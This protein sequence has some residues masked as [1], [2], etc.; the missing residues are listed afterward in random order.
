MLQSL[1]IA[2]DRAAADLIAGV[3]RQSG[4]IS[5]EHI[6]CPAPTHYQLSRALSTLALDAVFVDTSDGGQ[7][8][9]LC[10][11]IARKTSRTAIVGFNV[12]RTA[13]HESVT[14]HMLAWPLSSTGVRETVRRAVRETCG[15]A[16][17]NLFCVVPAKGGSGATTVTVNVACHLAASF[18]KSVLVAEADLR[19]GTIADRLSTKAAQSIAQSL[20]CAGDCISLIWPRHVSRKFGVDWMLTN[21]ERNTAQPL[22]CDYRHLL[23][24]ASGRYD[25][26]LVDLPTLVDEDAAEVALLSHK[27][28]VV[29]TPEVLSL[30][31]ARQ[32]VEEL[33]SFGVPRSRI[34]VLVNRLQPRDISADDIGKTLGCEV[35]GV[36]PNDYPAVNRSILEG[37]FVNDGTKLGRAYRSLAGVIA[38]NSKPSLGLETRLSMFGFLTSPRRS[39]ARA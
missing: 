5:L 20:A 6:H 27:V 10:E 36:F 32:R 35:G 26:T 18:G 37:N 2:N 15:T 13:G 3:I 12:E 39:T 7:A 16:L 14:P 31:L 17:N 29:T 8:A 11:E 23:T 19:S 30:R 38:G 34:Q 1:L 28:F 21:R 24:F 25:Y 33:E 22:W 4:Q 9:M